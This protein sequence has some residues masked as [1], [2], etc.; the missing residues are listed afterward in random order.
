MALCAA[1]NKAVAVAMTG[2]L[3]AW[4]RQAKATAEVDSDQWWFSS[5]RPNILLV[6]VADQVPD[7]LR[8]YFI[9]GQ[10]DI[11]WHHLKNLLGM[12]KEMS[13]HPSSL[14]RMSAGERL[15]F[16]RTMFLASSSMQ[17]L[18]F[19][20]P[21]NVTMATHHIATG[22]WDAVSD[23]ATILDTLSVCCRKMLRVVEEMVPEVMEQILLNEAQ[24]VCCTLCIS[25]RYSMRHLKRFDVL[26]VD[27]ASQPIESEFLISTCLQ[28]RRCILVGDPR[29]L[30]STV[31]SPEA[32]RAG[33]GRSIMSRLLDM[34]SKNS[35][36]TFSMLDT[37]YRMHPAISKW[38][39]ERFYQSKLRND[40]TVVKR[41]AVVS[42]ETATPLMFVDC[43]NGC[44]RRRGQNGSWYNDVEAKQVMN[45]LDDLGTFHHVRTASPCFSISILTFYRAQVER[46]RTLLREKWA[47]HGSGCG[48]SGA[49]VKVH[50]VDSMQGSEADVVILSFVRSTR[51]CGFLADPRRLNVAL[52]RAKSN[53]FLVGR[54]AALASSDSSDIVSLMA[55]V[56]E[57][58]LVRR[59]SN[60]QMSTKRSTWENRAM[61]GPKMK[62]KKSW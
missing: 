37:Q 40:V 34:G 15:R 49:I 53:L 19:R 36:A 57:R 10:R 11:V 39:N 30:S 13:K 3:Q 16:A 38:P 45:I 22:G 28:P 14:V 42:S 27:E 1:T 2:F 35:G 43:D 32:K 25:G 51:K 7:H 54:W 50:T 60:M 55:S 17:R 48:R 52:T 4:E 6:G 8:E 5:R 61:A 23:P 18:A 12:L 46:I 33:F 56:Q 20:T 44:E 47:H 62:K 21:T 26:V 31:E 9:H 59:P 29:Q 24:M 41:Q 58:D